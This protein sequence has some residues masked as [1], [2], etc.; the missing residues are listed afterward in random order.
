MKPCR[1]E[2]PASYVHLGAT[3]KNLALAAAVHVIQDHT[4]GSWGMSVAR[5]VPKAPLQVLAQPA[6]QYACQG[7]IRAAAG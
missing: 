2:P 7:N 6:A 5:I 4:L 1:M 3:L